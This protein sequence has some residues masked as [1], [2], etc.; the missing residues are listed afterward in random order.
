MQLRDLWCATA[1]LGCCPTADVLSARVED[2][3][4]LWQLLG[5]KLIS[6]D[7]H[8]GCWS[9]AER[10]SAALRLSEVDRQVREEAEWRTWVGWLPDYSR[11]TPVS[12]KVTAARS[13]EAVT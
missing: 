10:L 6:L 8:A 1:L 5:Q 3:Y 12:V 4:S 13:V 2:D 11:Q 7:V 9:D